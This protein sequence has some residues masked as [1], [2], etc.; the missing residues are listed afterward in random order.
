LRI[1]NGHR[2]KCGYKWLILCLSFP[3]WNDFCEYKSVCKTFSFFYLLPC[4]VLSDGWVENNWRACIK[5]RKGIFNEIAIELRTSKIKCIVY[6]LGT[7]ERA[8]ASS[9][10]IKTSKASHWNQEWLPL[11]DT[12]CPRVA[13]DTI[14]DIYV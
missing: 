8:A 5:R 13:R 2:K 7:K 1:W 12:T 10:Q 4:E 11:N 14:S 9:S 3:R 6:L